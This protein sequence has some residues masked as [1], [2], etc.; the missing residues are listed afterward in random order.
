[1]GKRILFVKKKI[2]DI[3]LF[4]FFLL[5][6]YSFF[7]KTRIFPIPNLCIECILLFLLGWSV[8]KTKYRT[9]FTTATIVFILAIII[10]PILWNMTGYQNIPLSISILINGIVSLS[11]LSGWYTYRLIKKVRT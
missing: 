10:D 11:F 9:I 7:T 2:L 4:V 1:M 3:I 6:F 5:I 8:G